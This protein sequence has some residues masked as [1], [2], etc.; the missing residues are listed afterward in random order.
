VLVHSALNEKTLN[1]QSVNFLN[2]KYFHKS[3]RL[4]IHAS[5]Y[6]CENC[7]DTFVCLSRNE[8]VTTKGAERENVFTPPKSNRRSADRN[9][10]RSGGSGGGSAQD[11][12]R[13]DD[14]PTA[15]QSIK[16]RLGDASKPP[17]DPGYK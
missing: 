17:P 9:L 6:F 8:A 11:R 12:L 1:S 4:A 3:H 10:G 13:R 5:V 15:N 2:G 16:S 7:Y 14:P